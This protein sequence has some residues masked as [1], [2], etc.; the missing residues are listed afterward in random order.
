L[1]NVAGKGYA[2]F[3]SKRELHSNRRMRLSV[4]PNAMGWTIEGLPATAASQAYKT[5]REAVAAA[6]R[7]I[8][9]SAGG[10]VVI[11]SRSGR[12]REVDTYV[13]GRSGFEKISAVEG[14][15]VSREIEHDFAALDRKGLSP[16]E[17]RAW[18]IAKYGSRCDQLRRRT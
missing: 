5:Q 18:L 16:Q 8:R 11:R 4:V 2:E 3:M 14:I 15:T 7:A 13:L 10:E 12:V 6:R 9:P 1:S 17:R